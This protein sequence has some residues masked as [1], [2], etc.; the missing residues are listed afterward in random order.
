MT[1]PVGV[2][3]QAGL[4]AAEAI[5]RGCEVR[6]VGFERAERQIKADPFLLRPTPAP[7]PA[8]LF[9]R[10]LVVPAAGPHPEPLVPYRDARELEI[11][12]AARTVRKQA[13]AAG[14][15]VRATYALGW[16]VD[17]KGVTRA[18]T[19]TLALRMSRGAVAS[20]GQRLVAVWSAKETIQAASYVQGG[21]VAV[22]VKGWKF[23][24]A[25]GWSRRAPLHKLSSV[26]MKAE[27]NEE[28]V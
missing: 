17:S 27:I 7:Q 23:D 15:C 4:D 9:K 6:T 26:S 13:E 25:Y 21:A 16:A 22:P 3:G 1:V 10:N 12:S 2:W 24:M 18:L 14:W 19:H 8:D 20:G 5:Q 11:P 28:A